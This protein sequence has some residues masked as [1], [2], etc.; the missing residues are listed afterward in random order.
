MN[1]YKPIKNTYLVSQTHDTLQQTKLI[2][3]YHKGD[4]M[5]DDMMM[6]WMSN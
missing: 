5:R 1:L 3:T 6:Q 4:E 2:N